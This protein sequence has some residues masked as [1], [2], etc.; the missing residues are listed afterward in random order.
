MHEKTENK[1]MTKYD[2][3]RFVANKLGD[4]TP[5]KLQKLVYY[6]YA[7]GLVAVGKPLF[8]AHFEAWKFGPV[9][10]DLYR[11]Y[12]SFGN[13]PIPVDNS[14][15]ALPEKLEELVHFIVD[16]YGH[17]TALELS[18]TSHLEKPWKT[19]APYAG[20]IPDDELLSFYGHADFARNFP[21]DR[22]RRYTPP[23]TS[24]DLNY[25]FDLN[26]KYDPSYENIDE[27]LASVRRA[28]HHVRVSLGRASY[29][30]G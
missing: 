3:A 17:L 27:Y 8:R 10:P 30:V 29:D 22:T 21:I 6:V 13:S 14:V 9:D 20:L 19:H 4:V 24:A 15:A 1:A 11:T 16:S 18:K 2:V 7:W 12:K 28:R 26:D 25:S 23:T 5:M